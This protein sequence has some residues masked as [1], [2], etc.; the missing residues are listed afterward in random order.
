[1]SEISHK[2]ADRCRYRQVS[3]EIL[4]PSLQIVGTKHLNAKEI[5]RF[6]S[7]ATT[8]VPGQTKI[9]E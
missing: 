9:Q 2:E 1:M 8:V 5:N 6:Q 4:I 3:E 7:Q